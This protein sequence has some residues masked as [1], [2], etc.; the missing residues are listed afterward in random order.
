MA[1]EVTSKRHIE[2][3]PFGPSVYSK[4]LPGSLTQDTLGL[5]SLERDLSTS[6]LPSSSY[7]PPDDHYKTESTAAAATKY[8]GLTGTTSQDIQLGLTFTV[9]FLSI[10]L[11]GINSI[12][13][14]AGLGDILSGGLGLFS[15]ETL[16]IGSLATVAVIAIA[17]IFVLPQA[18]YWITGINLSTFTL[19]RSDDG[20]DGAS[21]GLVSLAN[22]VDMALTEFSID[23]KG[24]I[25][26]SMCTTL[27]DKNKKTDSVLVKALAGSALKNPNMMAFLGEDKISR[28]G[29]YETMATKYGAKAGTCE[30]VFRATCPWDTA[31]MTSIAM[32]LM[33]SQGTNLADLALKAAAAA[34]SSSK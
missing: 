28:L 12:L 31:G 9:P 11:T 24:C 15:L 5:D 19:G 30:S 10:P 32:K 3:K 7:D 18:I 22:T 25:A 1:N 26:K 34:A 33:A 20:G 8:F 14:G 27:F 4:Y 29:E 17:A 16:D 21:S 23:G 2:Q 13:S 6:Y